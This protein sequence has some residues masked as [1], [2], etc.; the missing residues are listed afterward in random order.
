MRLSEVGSPDVLDKFDATFESYWR[1]PEYVE[2]TGTPEETKRFD[3]A[4]AADRADSLAAPLTFL[5]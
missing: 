1:S 3:R 5:E 2:Y 4:V